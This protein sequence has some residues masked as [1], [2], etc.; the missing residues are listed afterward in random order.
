M[1]NLFNLDN[2]IMVFLA[3]VFDM[4]Y[5]NI[6]TFVCCIPIF[7]IGAAI[8]A[9]DTV[10]LKLIED[11]GS[12][13]TKEF[14]SAFK[15]NFKK[16]TIMWLI[17]LVILLVVGTDLFVIYNQLVQLPT[18][19]YTVLL[20]LSALVFLA[21]IYTFA[22]QSHYE[23]TVKNTMKNAWL[24]MIGNLPRSFVMLLI[25][26]A[27]LLICYLFFYQLLPFIVLFGLTA[28]GWMIMLLMKGI[29][30]KLDPKE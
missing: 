9:M 7:T 20:V 13:V 21:I 11:R 29:F 17:Y 2:P 30:K 3:R 8:T 22:L 18:I 12:G 23:N 19:I 28:P 27:W 15:S 26:I 14:F 4:M 25:V 16:S 5:L 24:L 10:E 6:L 1:R